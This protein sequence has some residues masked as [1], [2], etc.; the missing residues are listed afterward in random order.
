[1]GTCYW[2]H[3]VKPADTYICLD[4][5]NQVCPRCCVEKCAVETPPWFAKCA[6]AG[7]PT[8]PSVKASKTVAAKLVCL[9]SYWN[10]DLFKTTSVK[11]F[12]ESLATLIRPR[13]QLAHRFVESERGLAYYTR[14]PEGLLWQVPESWNTPIYYLAFHGEPG[15]VKSVLDRIDSEMLLQ[16]FRDYG[17]CGYDNLV[18]FAA[19]S[20]LCGPEGEKF[21]LDFLAA[22]GCRAIIGYTTPVDWMQSLVTDLLFLQRFYTNPDPWEN[23]PDIFDS[24]KKDYRPAEALGYTLI[25]APK[26]GRRL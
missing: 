12:F 9:E 5:T 2:N 26:T 6:E 16:A 24:V 19:C 23:L 10:Q 21:A 17:S 7:H 1:M 4:G 20:V 18:Y 15:S 22:S 13:L 3:D 14:Y 8:W 11:G 25:E